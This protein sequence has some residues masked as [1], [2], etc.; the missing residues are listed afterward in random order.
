M[1]LTEL[2]LNTTAIVQDVQTEGDN[3]ALTQ[4]L[5]ALGIRPQCQVCVLR[6][7]GFGG[8]LHVR[9][10]ATTEVALRRHE[11]VQIL[12]MPIAESRRE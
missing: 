10:G 9:V 7:A 12:V 2:T 4:R 8:P 5:A 6:K 1:S 11:A 3:I